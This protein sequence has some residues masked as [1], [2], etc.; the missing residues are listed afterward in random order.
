M[1]KPS[2]RTALLVIGTIL[3]YAG[4]LVYLPMALIGFALAIWGCYIW[5]RLK[6]QNRAYALLG[7]LAPLGFIGL[8]LLKD[9]TPKPVT[10]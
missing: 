4:N 2:V 5:A 6:N 9:R 1:N 8:A 3:I 7:I 10:A